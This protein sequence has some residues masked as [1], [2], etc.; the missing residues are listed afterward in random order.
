MYQIHGT[1]KGAAPILINRF[2]EASQNEMEK[3]STG[4]KFTKEQRIA[5]AWESVYKDEQGYY[6]P[7]WNLKCCL[8]EGAKRGSIK[9]G[10]KSIAPFLQATV[11][12]A[13]PVRFSI[14]EAFLHETWG[15]RPPR[16]GGAC[17]VRRPGFQVGWELPFVLNVVDDR[18]TPEQIRR[19]LEE[20]GLLVG[21]GSW[22]PEYGRCTV[23]A[24]EVIK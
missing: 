20:A 2:T 24:W 5:Q 10:K 9:E 19:C 12:P 6:L 21:L 4:G 11:F 22:R 1:I 8:V 3:S 14:A 15:R 23:A 18:R 16:T 7:A 17:M 13:D